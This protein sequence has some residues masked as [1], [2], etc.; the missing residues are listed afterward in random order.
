MHDLPKILVVDDD[1]TNLKFLNEILVDDFE[2]KAVSTGED[3]LKVLDEFEPAI[4]LLDVM[5]PGING[6]EVCQKVRLNKNL[7]N[8]KIILISAKAMINERQKGFEVGAD[9]Y[10]TKPFDHE[11]LLD[12]IKTTLNPEN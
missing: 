12:K 3:A 10:I 6:Y 5:L 1:Q 7:P 4:I 9:D 11:R 8:I 2:L